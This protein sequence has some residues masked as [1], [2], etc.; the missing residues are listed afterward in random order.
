MFESC[1]IFRHL[2][3]MFLSLYNGH[4]NRRIIA[5]GYSLFN[6]LTATTYANKCDIKGVISNDLA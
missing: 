2:F 4:A 1:L 6:K 3:S 5:I